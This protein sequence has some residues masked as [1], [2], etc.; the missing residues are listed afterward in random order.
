[1]KVRI[2]TGENHHI[3]LS[4]DGDRVLMM[5]SE[6]GRGFPVV[7]GQSLD[8][9]AIADLHAALA[10]FGAQLSGGEDQGDPASPWQMGTRLRFKRGVYKAFD[11]LIESIEFDSEGGSRFILASGPDPRNLRITVGQKDLDAGAEIIT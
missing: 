7:T 9:N 11:W 10:M 1:M 4:R 8:L 5:C 6:P 3:E 2:D